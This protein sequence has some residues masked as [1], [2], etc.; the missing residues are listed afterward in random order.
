MEFVQ[1]LLLNG[2]ISGSSYALMAVGFVVIYRSVRFF[3][4][5][6]GSV[7]L[8]GAYVGY[9]ITISFGWNSM[10]SFFLRRR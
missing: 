7:F 5:A 10:L 8:V 9:S 2:I 1:Q 4:F 3:H 6:H